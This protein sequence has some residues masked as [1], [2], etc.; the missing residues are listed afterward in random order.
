[1]TAMNPSDQLRIIG[2][3]MNTAFSDRPSLDRLQEKPVDLCPM[4]AEA[5]ACALYHFIQETYGAGEECSLWSP[6]QA[7][8]RGYGPFWRVSWEAGP[9]EWGVLLTLGESMWLTEWELS[10]DHRP[11]VVLQ[12]GDGWYTEPHYR[13]DVGFFT[14]LGEPARILARVQ[15]DRRFDPNHRNRR[16]EQSES[17]QW[18]LRAMESRRHRPQ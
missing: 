12:R 1:M 18:G 3:V 6:Q 11:E 16:G 9:V 2:I 4:T 14:D 7:A 10:H 13:F 17:S 8:K 15:V 5:A